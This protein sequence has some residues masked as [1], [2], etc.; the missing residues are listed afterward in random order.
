VREQFGKA[1][2][3]AM[4]AGTPVFAYDCGA[5][6]EV[7]GSGGVVVPE[8]DVDAMVAALDRHFSSTHCEREQLAGR[9]R[10]QAEQYTDESV[11]DQLVDVWSA[12]RR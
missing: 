2:V 9:A 8:G 10:A 7:I 6:G 5:L 3:E 11:A 4:L 12:V 1:A